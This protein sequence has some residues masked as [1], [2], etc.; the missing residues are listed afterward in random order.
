MGKGT[1][2][3]RHIVT[4]HHSLRRTFD[5][6]GMARIEQA[7][8]ESEK[9]HGGQV[10]FAVES[11]LPLARVHHGITPRDRALEV[12][13]LL[14]V[15][16]TEHN[17]GV[18]IYLLLADHD[19]E[20]VADRGIAD[21][22]SDA[23]WHAICADVEKACAQGRYVDGVADGIRASAAVIA[24]RFAYDA[25]AARNELPDRPVVL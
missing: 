12:F 8:A 11:A 20:I 25:S 2:L 16:D 13:G 22:E 9:T 21:S 7:I 5:A 1:R 24:R 19:V 18:L 14:R 17:N 6:A 4:D 3:W 23:L 10:V 15:W